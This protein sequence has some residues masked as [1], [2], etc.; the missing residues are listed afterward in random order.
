MTDEKTNNETEPQPIKL[1]TYLP[2]VGSFIIFLGVARLIFF[3]SAFGVSIVN[4]LDF[5]EIIT[6][7]L[8]IIVIAVFIFAYSFLQG[9]ILRNKESYDEKDELRKQILSEG[10]FLKRIWLHMKLCNELFISGLFFIAAFFAWHFFNKDITYSSILW[11]ACLYLCIFGLLVLMTEISRIHH[12]SN[13]TIHYRRFIAMLFYT[14]LLIGLVIYFAHKQVT[15]IKEDKST[16]GVSIILDNDQ[17][18]VSDSTNYYVGKTVNYLFFHHEKE[19]TT[20]VIPMTRV[21][22]ITYKRKVVPFKLHD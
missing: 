6:S 10:N 14:V 18:I 11:I 12:H 3:Y 19:N 8:D 2:Y 22:Q 1:T 20:D 9:F 16:Y 13:S 15:S 17:T 4:F 21:K 7:F 5:S